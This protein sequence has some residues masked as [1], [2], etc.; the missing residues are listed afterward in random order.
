MSLSEE[1]IA[2]NIMHYDIRSQYAAEI[3]Y[4]QVCICK[5]EQ[6]RL[7][8]NEVISLSPKNQIGDNKAKKGRHIN[9]CMVYLVSGLNFY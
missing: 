6:I 9:T 8:A 2:L 5:H 3:T 7:A 1:P 4:A